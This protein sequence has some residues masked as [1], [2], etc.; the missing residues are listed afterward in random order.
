MAARIL[1]VEDEQIIAAD[2]C[3]KLTRMGHQIVGI[4]I[5]ADEAIAI[6]DELKPDLVLMDVQLDGAMT[7]TEAA[8]T[9]QE[10]TGAPVVYVTAFPGI[11]VR[12][13][14]KMQQP[15]ICLGKPFSRLQLEA[16][17]H[18]ALGTSAKP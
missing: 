6:A 9:I 4:A 1:V 15:G 12:D 3:N 11:F 17:V 5:A 10:R 7:G 8:C 14:T 18:A 2:L 16:A 13:P